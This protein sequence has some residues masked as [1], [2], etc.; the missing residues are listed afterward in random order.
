MNLV[1][2]VE[3][4]AKLYSDHDALIFEGAKFS[5]RQ[6]N[7]LS[8]RAANALA[9]LGIHRGDR[10]ALWLPNQPEF[11]FAFLGTL[12]LGAIAVTINAALKSEETQF[13]LKDSGSK[14]LITSGTLRGVLP[15]ADAMRSALPHLDRVVLVDGAPAS[16]DT[17]AA[18]SLAESPEAIA[19]EVTA[20][21]P[22]V[23]H[24]TSGT[25]GFPKGA[26][27][28]HHN[29]I[30]SS[31]TAVGTLSVQ[32]EDRV[33]LCLPL[34]FSFP[35][36]AVL[37]P[38][39]EAGAT[40][41]L[42]RQFEPESVLRSIEEHA[43]TL[44]FGVPTLYLMLFEQSA[45]KQLISIRRAVSAGA[46]L[47]VELGSKWLEKYGFAINEGYGLTETCMACFNHDPRSKPGSVG[48]TIARVEVRV[49]GS[50][51]EAGKPGDLGEIAIRGPSVM[52]GYWNR[53]AETAEK[54]HD[55]WFLSGDI[56]RMDDDGCLY[57]VDRIK[58][59][60]NV[61]GMKVFPS[62]V[63]NILYQ[64][65]DIA[66]VAV[67]GI[68]DSISEEKVCAA[69][70]LRPD[71]RATVNDI[72]AFC[73]KNMADFKVPSDVEFVDALPKSGSGK[74]LKRVLR[75]KKLQ[76][77]AAIQNQ[78]ALDRR[79]SAKVPATSDEEVFAKQP[80]SVEEHE[81]WI[82]GWLARNLELDGQPVDA[83]RRFSDYGM[84][85]L[86]AVG[87]AQ[88][89]RRLLAREVSPV[90][91]WAHPTPAELARHLAD[92][93]PGPDLV[94]DITPLVPQRLVL[95]EEQRGRQVLAGGR[96]RSD[97][98]SCNY[99]GL[100]LHPK[101]MEAIAPAVAKWGVHP[102]WSRQVATPRI[103]EELESEL[104]QLVGSPEVLVFPSLS[105]L[106]LGIIPKLVGRDGV[107]FK[108]VAAHNTMYEACCRAT[109]DGAELVDYTHNDLQALERQ[110]VRFPH[111][112]TKL[113]VI[114]GVYSMS[115]TFSDLPAYV[116]LAKT[117]NA[118]IYI[119]DA[120]GFGVIGENPNPGM[121]YG[122]KGNGLVR[123]HGLRY[124]EDNITYVAGLSKA[125]S[126]YGAFMTVPDRATKARLS[127]ET[128]TFGYS[129]PTCVASLASAIAGVRLNRDEG[130]RWRAQLLELTRKLVSGARA[131]GFAVNENNYFPLVAVEVGSNADVVEAC[132]ILW[133]HDVLITPAVYPLVPYNK[134]VLRFSITAANTTAEVDQALRALADVKN[135]KR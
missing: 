83:Q 54:L 44:F 28:S 14:V 94:E 65:R 3:R 57:I 105:L 135:R 111:S 98:A 21:H 26:L 101:V 2:H 46:K 110:L 64:N 100:D 49:V 125:F 72:L 131:L 53:P 47:P 127:N 70:V 84:T 103:Y 15:A 50:D 7:E 71:S 34:F 75:D 109:V 77:I 130:G 31:Q 112:R 89:L 8:N 87:L 124:A 133:E 97:F 18:L 22:A 30:V 67:Y 25:T 37:N 19:A 51:G 90:V 55:G 123:F 93:V 40:L 91:A 66:E 120:H 95:V 132:R 114:D 6:L 121:P 116:R 107:I 102:S 48:R 35:Q 5:Y 126:S 12:K 73:R 106:H 96:W 33:L 41:V 29:V 60:V 39:F 88:D 129:G 10:V 45:P 58:D 69:I 16:T 115:G 119:D 134:G 62:E 117:Y 1:Q 61:A 99:L 85:S 52:L 20:D 68:P 74:L 9:R 43:I 128:T 82:A 32:H 92:G 113:I 104:P 81:G 78:R 118:H 76:S 24:Y 59:M 122:Q 80:Q 23:I 56:G 17:F 27:L 38:C 13:I 11:V 42:H 63:E 4:A 36:T 86:L 79:Q 108:D